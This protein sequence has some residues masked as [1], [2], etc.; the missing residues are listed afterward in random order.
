[1]TLSLDPR[2]HALLND[3]Q[4]DLPL[5]PRP[6]A[7]IGA[8][9]GMSESEVLSRLQRLNAAGAISRV[10]GTFRPNTAGA[11]TLA[12]VAAPDWRIDEVAEAIG[13]L[14]GVNHSYLREHAYN[15]WFVA[16][17]PD[18]AHVDATLARVRSETGLGVLDLPL[19]RPFNVDLGFSLD[20]QKAAPAPRRVADGF[21]LEAG[22]AEILQALSEGLAIE[23]APF[24]E[25][26][27]R[28]GRDEDAVIARIAALSAA[29]VLSRLGVIVRHRALGWRSNAMVVWQVPEAD[30]PRAGPALA[31]T[32][33]VTLCYQRRTVEGVW[34][35]SLYCMIHARSRAEAIA[36][37]ERAAVAAGLEQTPHEVLFSLRCFKQ[38]G[39]LIARGSAAS[40][41]RGD[42]A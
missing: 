16:T 37:L 18:R 38:T 35:Y 29:G 32:P 27:A 4:R 17:G 19:V 12:A 20:A 9:T 5:E 36:T 33:G 6:F 25:L 41:S 15:L 21:V 28:L 40:H 7:R 31:A 2:D 11:S 10:G 1:M 3:W 23:P 8:A 13:R 30:I 42:A 22:D 26:A 14:E 39:A 34:P 24:A